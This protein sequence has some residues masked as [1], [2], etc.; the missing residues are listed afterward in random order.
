M[1]L[2]FRSTSLELNS[3]SCGSSSVC[4]S[5]REVCVCVGFN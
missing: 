1:T 4:V 2:E 5:E 3:E